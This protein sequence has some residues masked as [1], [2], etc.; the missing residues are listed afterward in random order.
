M[1]QNGIRKVRDELVQVHADEGCRDDKEA[2]EF[3]SKVGLVLYQSRIRNEA[4]RRYDDKRQ[5][6]KLND[7]EHDVRILDVGELNDEDAGQ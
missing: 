1:P 4:N 5:L 7:V 3:Y 6:D 2:V